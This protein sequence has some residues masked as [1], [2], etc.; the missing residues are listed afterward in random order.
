MASL[1]EVG[2]RALIDRVI[3][4]MRA[5]NSRVGPGDDAACVDINGTSIVVSTDIVTFEKHM[6]K[7]MTMEQFGWLAAAVSFSDIAS[8]GARPVGILAAVS[9]PPETDEHV[10]YDI[11]SGIDQCAEFCGAEVLGGDTKSGHGSVCGTALGVCENVVL[12]RSG[13]RPGDMVAVTGSLGSASAGWYASLNDI[14]DE[15]AFSAAALP[16]PRIK[17]GMILSEHDIATSCMD[18]SDG[19][20]TT[21]EAICRSSGVG[22]DIIW[23]LL[24]K[25]GGVDRICERLGLSPRQLMLNGGGEYELM[26]T[27]PKDRLDELHSHDIDFAVIGVVTLGNAVNIITGGIPETLE[28]EGYEHFTKD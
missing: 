2:E 20:S 24:P 25:G 5:G 21:A 18:I 28:N 8:M 23:E 17:E 9:L 19:L 22:M 13:A 1:K 26:F 27:F 4:N 7:G 6:I 11:M 12:R 16:I 10:L 15:R 14:R 3:N